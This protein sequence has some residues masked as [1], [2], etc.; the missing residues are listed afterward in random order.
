MSIYSTAKYAY[1]VLYAKYWGQRIGTFPR[2]FEVNK[3]VHARLDESMKSVPENMSW[4]GLGPHSLD[5]V[6]FRVNR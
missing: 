5:T 2:L 6:Y 1:E 3:I 4:D